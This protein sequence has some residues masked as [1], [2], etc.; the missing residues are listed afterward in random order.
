MEITPK[1]NTASL[2]TESSYKANPDKWVFERLPLND[3]QR[4]DLICGLMAPA[5]PPLIPDAPPVP[6][7][8]K[9]KRTR[10]REPMDES[11]GMDV[12]PH[13]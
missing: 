5:P 3:W 12:S 6:P 9:R 13:K 8:F 10:K 4:R 11:K 2:S 1:D 7:A